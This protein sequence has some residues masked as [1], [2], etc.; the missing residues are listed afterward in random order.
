MQDRISK[1][2]G[3]V[4][5]TPVAGQ[6]NI[7]DLVRADEPEVEGTP[8]NKG[9][10]LSDDTAASFGLSG[11]MATPDGAFKVTNE[12]FL[13]I[14]N[15]YVWMYEDP[16]GN[17]EYL[18][19]NHR[20]AYTEGEI[21]PVDAHIEHVPLKSN[22][23]IADATNYGSRVQMSYYR[24]NSVESDGTLNMKATSSG[25]IETRYSNSFDG[26]KGQYFKY[27]QTDSSKPIEA[28]DFEVGTLYYMPEDAVI[29]F[30]ET[31]LPVFTV[32]KIYKA[33]GVPRSNN[34]EYTYIGQLG[35][36]APKVAAGSYK[37]TGTYGESNPMSLTFDFV[38]KFLMFVAIMSYQSMHDIYR[39]FSTFKDDYTSVLAYDAL[40]TEYKV[41]YAFSNTS[42][43]VSNAY[44][45]KSADGKTWSWYHT[46][47]ANQQFNESGNTYYWL[48]IG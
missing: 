48:A 34:G 36:G 43:G 6:D 12:R 18:T 15:L 8:L 3:R 7:F 19:G 37:G 31:N 22:F 5:L 2:P 30:D 24:I 41:T 32:D 23:L 38:P 11:D 17:I 46:S 47:A 27:N 28:T 25:W 20:N 40:R 33:V 29:T 9:N 14:G 13:N 21:D 39:M 42:S 4:R 45:K 1:Y 26:L 44:A 35:E 16:D 10:L